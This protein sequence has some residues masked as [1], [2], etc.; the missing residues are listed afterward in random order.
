[1]VAQ[2]LSV[3]AGLLIAMLLAP[4]AA[5]AP[6]EVRGRVVA[7]GGGGLA[8]AR[9]EV[10]PLIPPHL[11]AEHQL[12]GRLAPEA[13]ARTRSGSGGGFRLQAPQAGFWRLVVRHP[14]YLGAR[15]DLAALAADRRLADLPLKRRSELAARLVGAD[16]EPLAG[17]LVAARGWSSRWRHLSA[18]GWWPADRTVQSAGDG[19]VA[20]PCAAGESVSLAAFHRGHYL[21]RIVPCDAQGVLLELAEPLSDAVVV[22]ADGEAAVV[23]GFL[24]WPFLA[25]GASDEEGR[26]RAPWRPDDPPPVAF[27]DGEGFYAEPSLGWV[28][29]EDLPAFQLA[30]GEPIAG[31]VVDV[32]SRRPLA[33]AWLW[34]GRGSHHFRITGR[35]GTFRWRLP[36]ERAPIRSPLSIRASR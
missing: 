10:Q 17:V 27:A 3:P 34:L 33:G 36:A 25:F 14:A 22:H 11:A 7:E 32:L 5:A 24:R 35:D 8:A 2:H 1:M 28:E 6:I 21:H 19:A 12:A 4:P 16:G 20:V 23:Q 18:A 29:A 15:A 13:A 9:I 26:I 31:R 30:A